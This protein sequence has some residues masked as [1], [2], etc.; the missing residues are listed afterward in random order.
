MAALSGVLWFGS[1]PPFP[2]WPMAWVAMVPLLLVLRDADGK[3]AFRLG[4]V[5][6][7]VATGGG[8]PWIPELI[9]RFGNLPVSVAWFV[10]LLYTLYQGLIFALIAWGIHR[11][12][13]EFPRI[14][15]WVTAP[16]LTAAVEFTFPL[17]FP[18][19]MSIT[20]GFVPTAIQIAEITGP[21]GVSALLVMF[22]A[23]TARLIEEAILPRKKP[24][25]VLFTPVL[26][27]A[28]LLGWSAWR[29]QD[30][31]KRTEGRP[32]LHVAMVQPNIGISTGK[33]RFFGEHQLVVHH[34]LSREAERL[35][36]E[37]VIPGLDLLVWSES[38]YPYPVLRSR[39]M[40]YED[41]PQRMDFRRIQRGFS[42]PLLMGATT[43]E[44]EISDAGEDAGSH[45]SALLIDREGR[46]LSRYDKNWLLMFGEYIPLYDYVPFLHGFFQKHRMSNMVRGTRIHTLDLPADQ[47]GQDLETVRLGPMICYED[48]LPA[49]GRKAAKKGP[50]IL[51]NITND[52]WFG[53]SSQEPWQHL[54]LAVFRSVETRLPMVRNVNI[55]VSTFILPTGEL[56]PTA[57]AVDPPVNPDSGMHPLRFMERMESARVI[58][59]RGK[60]GLFRLDRWPDSWIVYAPVPV[61]PPSTTFYV[62]FGDV[63]AWLCL[64]ASLFWLFWRPAKARVIRLH[65]RLEGRKNHG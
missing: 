53:G 17:I 56:G 64:L 52:A 10:F 33:E 22:S 44:R 18:W 29:L 5:T 46:F 4:W 28:F 12:G 3:K 9:V 43:I 62:R 20:Q 25:P 65:Q 32:V 57:P 54:S 47:T 27:L 1:C 15:L 61:M 24:D 26:I 7:I 50:N 13:K 59:D 35:R 11:T 30:V 48:I 34:A 41:P 51:V 6:G 19:Y 37:K 58:P 55:G 21:T 49:F 36:D 8:F 38:S 40:D 31:R 16:I 45:N 14:P 42:T 2:L 63:F 60:P 23:F 39:K